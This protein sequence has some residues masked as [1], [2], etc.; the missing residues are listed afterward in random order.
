MREKEKEERD[1]LCEFIAARPSTGMEGPLLTQL[2]YAVRFHANRS[3]HNVR[4]C[5]Y[6]GQAADQS[7]ARQMPA[8][9]HDGLHNVI[10]INVLSRHFARPSAYAV[11]G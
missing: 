8:E 1:A 3:S 4:A 5:E 10:S 2:A 6:K 11:L 7:W 9:R